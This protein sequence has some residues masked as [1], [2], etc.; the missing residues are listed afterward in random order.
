MKKPTS[1]VPPSDV[2]DSMHDAQEGPRQEITRV[3]CAL[4][5]HC[6][7]CQAVG[8]PNPLHMVLPEVRARQIRDL[9][10]EE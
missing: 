6:R 5:E 3:P 7:G 8:V 10:E 1:T 9:D 2:Q 4:C